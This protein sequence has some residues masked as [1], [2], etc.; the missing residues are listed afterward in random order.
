MYERFFGTLNVLGCQIIY[1]IGMNN[2]ENLM[3][4]FLQN[5]LQMFTLLTKHKRT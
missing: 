3:N 4:F 1:F 5:N 2:I